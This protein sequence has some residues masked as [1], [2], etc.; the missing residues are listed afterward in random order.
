[1]IDHDESHESDSDEDNSSK[2]KKKRK[3]KIESK[4]HSSNSA[5]HLKEM[6]E[7]DNLD[8]D[9]L[10]DD[11]EYHVDS[12]SDIEPGE[13]CLNYEV[14]KRSLLK[15]ELQDPTSSFCKIKLDKNEHPI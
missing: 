6:T 3:N 4:N 10:E 15:S 2:T 12:D 9:E 1:V 7:R 8:S 14:L 11:E 5:Y 13:N